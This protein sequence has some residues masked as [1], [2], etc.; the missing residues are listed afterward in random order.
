MDLSGIEGLSE[1]HQAAIMAAHNADVEGLKA[2]N[3]KLMDEAK[4][5]KTSVGE[6]DLAIEEARKVA[7]DAEAKALESQGKYE[8]AQKL[9]EDE[10]AKLV[11]EANAN[12]DKYKNALE[13]KD[14]IEA[15]SP[16][17]S[18]VLDQFQ[19]AAEAVLNNAISITYDESGN[20]KTMYKHGD[21]E[22]SSQAE[23]LDGVKDDAMWSGMLK[24]AD[25]SGAGTKQS[26]NSGAS[27]TGDK[28]G[29]NLSARLKG[30]GLI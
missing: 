1:E 9:R 17:L 22:F 11:A 14:I 18:K 12:A 15:K 7:A 10:R 23:F 13:A 8:E 27:S 26:G 29:D 19:P 16:I 5:A 30:H 24:G 6:K 2:N 3:T 20:A 4:K 21:K 25:S 28:V